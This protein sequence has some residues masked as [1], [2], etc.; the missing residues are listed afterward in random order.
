MPAGAQNQRRYP[1]GC[2]RQCGVKSAGAGNCKV[3][4]ATF[5]KGKGEREKGNNALDAPGS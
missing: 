1:S 5:F 3:F 2:N 4:G